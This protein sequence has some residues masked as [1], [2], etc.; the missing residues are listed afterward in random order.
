M[1]DEGKNVKHFRIYVIYFSAFFAYFSNIT[2]N[3]TTA[4]AAAAAFHPKWSFIFRH[5]SSNFFHKKYETIVVSFWQWRT[6]TKRTICRR[7]FNPVVMIVYT[8]FYSYNSDYMF[9]RVRI[10]NCVAMLHIIIIIFQC[11]PF[12]IHSIIS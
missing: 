8:F 7:G 6:L 1:R 12:V 4:A 5:V 10:A 11:A 9:S 2:H 3:F